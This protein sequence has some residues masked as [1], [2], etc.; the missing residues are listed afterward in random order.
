MS[1]IIHDKFTFDT[2]GV[3]YYPYNKTKIILLAIPTLSLAGK[4]LHTGAVIVIIV[5]LLRP[6]MVEGQMGLTI[7]LVVW[8]SRRPMFKVPGRSITPGPISINI[9]IYL[10]STNPAAATSGD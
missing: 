7:M 8:F 4:P 6:P 5:P 3:F 9:S 2:P 10:P 1:Y